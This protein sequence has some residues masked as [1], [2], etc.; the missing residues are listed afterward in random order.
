MAEPD[1]R[2]VVVNAGRTFKVMGW[3]CLLVLLG[4]GGLI[5]VNSVTALDPGISWVVGLALLIAGVVNF[6]LFDA[7]AGMAQG[8]AELLRREPAN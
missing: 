7:V 5:I 1:A 2:A 4:A 6:A 8:L 3:L